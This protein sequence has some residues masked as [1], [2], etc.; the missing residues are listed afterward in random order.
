MGCHLLLQGILLIQ[1]SD[2]GLLYF[3]TAA[4]PGK[5]L[6]EIFSYGLR[7]GDIQIWPGGKLRVSHLGPQGPRPKCL[8]FVKEELCRKSG[9]PHWLSRLLRA[10]RF[11]LFFFSFFEKN[12]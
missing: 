6:L 3:L 7:Y 11:G 9:F 12:H 8:P 1:G 10:L 2:L 5:S 4:P